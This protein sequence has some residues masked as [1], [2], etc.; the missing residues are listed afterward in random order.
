[1][2]GKRQEG[3]AKGKSLS[4]LRNMNYILAID[5]GTTAFKAAVFDEYGLERGAQTKEYSILTE[6]AGWAEMDPE[7]YLET[8][9]LAT[10]AAIQKAGIEPE[11]I[12]SIG[13]S[14]QGETSIF[15][16]EEMKPLR[17]A[18]VWFDT[19]ATEEAEEIVEEFGIEQIQKKTGQVAADSIWPGAKLLWIKKHEP[20]LYQR[21]GKIVQLKGYFSY[22]LTGNMCCED[23]IL[24]SSMYWDINSRKY[25]SEMLDFL[26]ISENQLPK[27]ARP[28]E[29]MGYITEEAA[30]R[31]GLSTKTRVNIGGIDLGCGAIGVGNIYPGTFSDSMG[32]A[33]CTVTQTKKPVLDPDRQM[34]CYCSALPGHYMIHA[35]ATGGMF[36]RWFRDAFCELESQVEKQTGKNTYDQLDALAETIP[37]GADGLIALPHLQGSGPPD[38]NPN[39]KATFYGLTLAHKKGHFARAIMESV[40]MVLCRMIEGTRELG[41]DVKNVIVLGGGAKSPLWCQIMADATGL[42]IM[43]MKNQE[44]EC[45]LGAAILAGVAAGLWESVEQAVD[46]T[47]ERKQLYEP[48][49]KAHQEYQ[50]LLKEYKRLMLC[51]QEMTK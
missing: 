43:I 51:M 26:G 14:A 45:C 9:Q 46:A 23:S 13:M 36:M 15:L 40:A 33:I 21:I 38:F 8:F 34:P 25:W 17:N 6:H 49:P 48:D 19:R 32:S 27:I 7:V 39:M 50:K 16:D 42:P 20:E 29:D 47:V 10:R 2:K 30:I 35:Y 18:I 5:I 4:D 24:G 44:N 11:E 31:F 22:I 37:I 3:K 12:L 28:G 41:V 1:M